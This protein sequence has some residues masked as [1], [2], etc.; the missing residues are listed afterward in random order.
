LLPDFNALLVF[1]AA[2][3][4][5]NL[6]PGPDM[7]YVISRSLDQ[8]RRAGIVSALGIGAGTLVH[9]VAA[10]VGLSAIVLS[11]PI[12]F[13]VVRYA[14]AAYL[15]YLGVRML[16][17]SRQNAS[18]SFTKPVAQG[19]L[20]SIFRQGVITNVLNPKVALFFLAFLPQFVNYS[21]GSI[22]LQMILLGLIFDTSG[23]S[24]N[25]I[26]AALA[27]HASGILKEHSGFSFVQRTFPGIILVALGALVIVK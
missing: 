10:A 25:I 24:W 8:G 26:I 27:S 7:L 23:T 3:T 15:V 11:F 4:A 16:L 21:M 20:S 12:A 18:T 19:R 22:A 14:G 13:E 5:L 2:T 1:L 6:S 9:T 17:R